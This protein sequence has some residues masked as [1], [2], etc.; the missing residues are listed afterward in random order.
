M[1][2]VVNVIGGTYHERCVDPALDRLGGSGLRSAGILCSLGDAVEFTTFLDPGTEAEAQSVA[3]TLGLSIS[4][5][6]REGPIT[7]T[8]ETPL[9]TAQLDGGRQRCDP[10]RVTGDLIVGF[11]MVEADWHARA[12]TLV[13]DPQHSDPQAILDKSTSSRC[14]LLLNEH[15]AR[16][17]TGKHDTADAARALLGGQVGVVV[18]KQG[19]IGGLVVDRRATA[20]FGVVP[21]DTVAPIGSGDAF[22]AGFAHAWSRD[23]SD[24]AEAGRFASRVA[25]AHSLIGAP[26]IAPTVL[27]SLP[28]PLPYPSGIQPTVYLAGPFFSIAERQLIHQVRAALIHLGVAVFSPFHDIGLGGD[29]VA[30]QDLIALRQCHSVIALLDGADPG[31]LFEVGWATQAEIPVVGLVETV[32][33]HEWTMLRGTGTHIAKDL[34]TAC[35]RAAWAAIIMAASP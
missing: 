33:A 25:A 19:A 1:G 11:G 15:E 12:D 21:T 34:S 31:T 29:E 26:Q 24:P 5:H 23:H 16:R 2:D 14:A 27:T 22:T 10:V 35:Y 28:A 7:F 20:Q 4:T 9:S 6:A 8:Y 17:L 30:E 32:N 18:I 13:L 3:T